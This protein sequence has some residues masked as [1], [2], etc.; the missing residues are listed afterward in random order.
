MCS[1]APEK[2]A[3]ECAEWRPASGAH[4][5]TGLRVLVASAVPLPHSQSLTPPA[6]QSRLSGSLPSGRPGAWP[7]AGRVTSQ[8]R[9]RWH[10]EHLHVPFSVGCVVDI[11]VTCHTD[12]PRQ[13][14]GHIDKHHEPHASFIFTLYV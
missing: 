5:A 3:P 8:R 13:K 14:L 2:E 6:L 1:C 12:E 11:H 9:K 7:E 4:W 10:L